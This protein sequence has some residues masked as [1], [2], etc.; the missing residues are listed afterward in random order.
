MTKYILFLF[1]DSR[2]NWYN[3]SAQQNLAQF[4]F[5]PGYQ[6]NGKMRDCGSRLASDLKYL[7]IEVMD[8][9]GTILRTLVKETNKKNRNACL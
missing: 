4:V 5:R 2:T 7:S 1:S 6:L 8:I 3:I 9:A